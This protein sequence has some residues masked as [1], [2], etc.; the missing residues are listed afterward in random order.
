MREDTSSVPLCEGAEISS[1]VY[2]ISENR[3]LTLITKGLIIYLLTA[4]GM[5]AYLT[6]LDIQFNQPLFHLVI[7][8]TAILCAVLYHSWRS[9]NLGYFIFFLIYASIL[10]LFRDYINS[11]FYAILNDTIDVAS[12]YFDTEGMQYY[13]ERIANRY[14]AITIAVTLIGI[15]EN[16]LLNNYILRRARYMVAIFITVTINLVPFFMQREPDTLYGVM[17]ISGLF[18]T[19]CLKSGD[20]FL[21]S[22]NDHIFQRTKKGLSYTLDFKSLRQGMLTV[23]IFVVAAAAV[24]NVAEPKEGYDTAQVENPY[25]TASRETVANFIMLGIVGLFNYYPN[26]GGLSTGELGGVSSVRL[27]YQTDLTVEYTP[28]TTDRMYLKNFTGEHYVPYENRWGSWADARESGESADTAR[29]VALSTDAADASETDALKKAYEAGE[30]GSARAVMRVTNVEAPA[31]PYLPYYAET[32]R[33]RKGMLD[34]GREAVLYRQTKKTVY[35]PRLSSSETTVPDRQVDPGYLEVPAENESAVRE[36]ASRAGITDSDSPENVISKLEAYYQADVPYTI[37]PGATPRNADF[38]NYFIEENR[39]GYCAHFASA[40]TLVFREYGI[41]ARYCEG[42]ALD[43]EEMSANGE[44]VEDADYDDYYDGDSEIGRTAVVRT[45]LTDADAHAWVEVYLEGRGWVTA[46]VT[47]AA[48]GG[49]EDAGADFWE[50]F[51]NIFGDGGGDA[52]TS[53]PGTAPRIRISANDRVMRA[54]AFGVLVLLA[55]VAAGLLGKKVYPDL[56]YHAAYRKAGTSDRLIL[57]YSRLAARKRK[58]DGLFRGKMNYRDQIEALAAQAD[59]DSFGQ[60][61]LERL[62]GILERAGFSSRPITEEEQLFA[63]NEVQKLMKPAKRKLTK[64]AG[65]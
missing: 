54:A 38:I 53:D 5:G 25:K 64:T 36:L 20:H 35:Y 45:N 22:R 52:G 33:N 29:L 43:F 49:E 31:L 39:K 4:G 9:E 12:T 40:A 50:S 37:R 42:Y 28:Y 61:D 46:D 62:I 30:P 44:L 32:T 26:N 10:V 23:L 21:L 58:K 15:A 34:E 47:P 8:A 27:D 17:L 13:N 1:G 55:A 63:E 51:N 41:P 6:A 59:P 56:K 2:E 18:M 16:I 65:V 11:G 19:Y 60:A 3:Y 24:I 48:S 57:K 7:F 14:A